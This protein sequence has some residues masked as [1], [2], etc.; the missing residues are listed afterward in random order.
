ME[1]IIRYRDSNEP[2]K[3]NNTSGKRHRGVPEVV[4]RICGYPIPGTNALR[5]NPRKKF[6]RSCRPYAKHGAPKNHKYQIPNKLHG[7]DF[8]NAFDLAFGL[9]HGNK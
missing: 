9:N 8:Y 1:F 2:L 7:E 4:C 6:H 3:R 5:K